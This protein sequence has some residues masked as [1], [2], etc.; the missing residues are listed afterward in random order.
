MHSERQ[1]QHWSQIWK[2]PTSDSQ[3]EYPCPLS[4]GSLAW[5]RFGPARRTLPR[6]G[7]GND[8]SEG[9]CHWEDWN[10]DK[11][12][13]VKQREYTCMDMGIPGHVDWGPMHILVGFTYG[14]RTGFLHALVS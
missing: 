5:F 9:M 12:G 14:P 4:V 8:I 6:H 2:S 7:S 13:L 1:H 3:S 10:A 11:R